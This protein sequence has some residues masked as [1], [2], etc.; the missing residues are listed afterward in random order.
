MHISTIMF[1]TTSTHALR[2]LAHLARVPAKTYV[3]GRDL[4][5]AA[6]IPANYLSKIL[7]ALRNAGLVV[8]SRGCGGGYR[9]S[10]PP[11]EISLAEVVR[12][13]DGNRAAS[14]C[15]LA[16]ADLCSDNQPCAAHEQWRP[17]RRVYT[18]FIRSTSISDISGGAE[19]AQLA[20]LGK[21]GGAS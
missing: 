12:I 20:P 2:A 13:F 16:S 9:L 21:S 15:V 14:G 4:A 11:D 3:L 7:L 1:S 18:E 5:A 6:N 8:T 19:R 17:V 10:R